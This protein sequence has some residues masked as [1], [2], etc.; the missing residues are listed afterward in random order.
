MTEKAT[1]M[2]TDLRGRVVALE[3]GF[4]TNGTRLTNLEAWQR[5]RDIDSARHDERWKRMDDKIDAVAKKVDEVSGNLKWIGKTVIGAIILAVVAFMI[6]GGFR[7][8]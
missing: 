3:Q 1:D 5:Q 6:S 8:S 7:V 2:D 4:A